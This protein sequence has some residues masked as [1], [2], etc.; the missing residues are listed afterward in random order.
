LIDSGQDIVESVRH[1]L[2]LICPDRSLPGDEEILVLIG[3]PLEAVV[4]Q[5][6]Y[7]AD[8]ES[9]R[10]FAEA[11]RA[12]YAEHYND[13]TKVYPGI[14][15]LL[16]GL[17]Q[18]GVKLALVTTKHQSQAEFTLTGTGLL[19]YFDYVHGWLEGRRHKPDPEPVIAALSRLG[20]S[21]GSAIMVGDSE[22]DI[23]AAKAA[24]VDTCAVTYGFRPAWFLKSFRPDFLV[25]HPA[26]IGP[27][28]VS[29]E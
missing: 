2:S 26:D 9:T 28:V 3:L 8:T 24:G 23:E 25:A 7:P 12:Y 18:A 19:S 14:K 11:Y 22:L 17:Q 20:V 27:I 13:N 5:L 6:G 16:A 21:P 15:E 29:Q 10:R 1:A 4:R